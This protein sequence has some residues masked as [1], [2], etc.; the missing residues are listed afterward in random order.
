M[1]MHVMYDMP[2]GG[3]SVDSDQATTVIDGIVWGAGTARKF[4]L[5]RR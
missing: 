4:L 2:V 3:F 5:S 1:A